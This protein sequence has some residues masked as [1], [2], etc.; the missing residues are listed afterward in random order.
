MESNGF[1]G[2]TRSK[3]RLCSFLFMRLT[4]NLILN[5][6][7]LSIKPLHQCALI[8]PLRGT[9]RYRCRF[10]SDRLMSR[11]VSLITAT[12]VFL[13]G[14]FGTYRGFLRGPYCINCC[15]CLMGNRKDAVFL[16]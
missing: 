2:S 12:F 6:G 7:L 1:S 16:L 5:H 4:F 11:G 10:Q 15:G 3:L 13:E 9:C 14:I 8:H